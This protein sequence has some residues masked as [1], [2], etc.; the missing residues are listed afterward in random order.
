MILPRLF[1]KW[2]EGSATRHI[3]DSAR[4][5]RLESP[6]QIFKIGSRDIRGKGF[7]ALAELLPQR[8]QSLLFAGHPKNTPIPRF[9][10][11][12]PAKLGSETPTGSNDGYS[13]HEMTFASG[14]QRAQYIRGMPT[15]SFVKNR[16][17][18]DVSAGANLMDS[19][20]NAGLPVAS[21]CLGD[22]VCGRC[23]IQIVKGA[24]SLSPIGTVEQLVRDRLKIPA[25]VRISCQTQVLGDITVDATY[26]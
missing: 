25:E 3:I 1:L 16:P 17:S 8:K 14:R 15:I 4:L 2:T 13:L 23:R 5:K 12:D 19:L 22:G 10:Q 18:I 7:E 11:H 26:W 9:I 6:E 20:L 24:E 21:S